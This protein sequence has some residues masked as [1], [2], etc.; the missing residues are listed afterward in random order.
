[1]EVLT[2]FMGDLFEQEEEEAEEGGVMLYHQE[3]EEEGVMVVAGAMAFVKRW[4]HHNDGLT[5][6]FFYNDGLSC[7][8][9]LCC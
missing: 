8:W 4:S 2:Y 9:F 6:F 7:D 5:S 1:M 3:E